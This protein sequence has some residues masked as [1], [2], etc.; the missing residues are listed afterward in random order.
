MGQGDS[1]Q[2]GPAAGPKLGAGSLRACPSHAGEQRSGQGEHSD[3]RGSLS[4][5]PG[6][7]AGRWASGDCHTGNLSGHLS[8][9]HAGLF[10][11]RRLG[12]P[13]PLEP[14]GHR[15][16]DSGPP[17]P[18]PAKPLPYP[19]RSK[20]PCVSYAPTPALPISVLTSSLEP[21]PTL[22]TPARPP[23]P[24]SPRGPDAPPI[25]GRELLCS[26]SPAPAWMLTCVCAR[27]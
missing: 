19:S 5:R 17:S 8:S 23:R 10:G 27:H 9:L 7:A 18:A 26:G 1:S 20:N 2:G 4:P 6:A 3:S 14:G 21:S 11:P 13:M 22:P 24:L 12:L 16:L 15:G 25:P